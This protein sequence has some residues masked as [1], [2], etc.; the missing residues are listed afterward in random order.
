MRVSRG[1]AGGGGVVVG[2]GGRPAQSFVAV[3]RP[4]AAWDVCMNQ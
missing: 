4:M 1:D 3:A 2:C